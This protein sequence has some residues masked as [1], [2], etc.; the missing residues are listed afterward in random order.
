MRDINIGNYPYIWT[1]GRGSVTWLSKCVANDLT[2][3][4][5]LN[6]CNHLHTVQ[7]DQFRFTTSANIRIWSQYLLLLV[8][9]DPYLKFSEVNALKKTYFLSRSTL[10]PC[11]D[12]LSVEN[13][14]YLTMNVLQLMLT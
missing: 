11:K 3:N 8:V 4:K 13:N 12:G 5:R 9:G 6:Q 1:V 10:V 2:M 14:K 7:M